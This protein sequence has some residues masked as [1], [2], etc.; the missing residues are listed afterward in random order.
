LSKNQS[1]N[2]LARVEEENRR[3]KPKSILLFRKVNKKKE[4]MIERTK[5]KMES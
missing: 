5:Q 4:E 3:I 1:E 2:D